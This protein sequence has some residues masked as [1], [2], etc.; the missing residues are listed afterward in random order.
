MAEAWGTGRLSLGCKGRQL[1]EADAENA[2][3]TS[4]K[5]FLTKRMW[6]QCGCALFEDSQGIFNPL[7]HPSF[8]GCFFPFQWNGLIS[9]PV[10]PKRSRARGLVGCRKAS[11]CPVVLLCSSGKVIWVTHIFP[12]GACD[13]FHRETGWVKQPK[14]PRSKG[15]HEEVA[16][17]IQIMSKQD[18][19]SKCCSCILYGRKQPLTIY[20]VKPPILTISRAAGHGC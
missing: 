14:P 12:R 9:S 11:S 3:L 17:T 20:W 8:G 6:V 19:G 4:T 10:R 7:P 18:D 5:G 13:V 2:R 16:L 15:N 1:S